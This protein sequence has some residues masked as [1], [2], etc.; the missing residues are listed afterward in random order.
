MI[1]LKIMVM[2]SIVVIIITL[3]IVTDFIVTCIVISTSH[4]VV[5]SITRLQYAPKPFSNH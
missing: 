4:C 3:M 5:I 1:M 2:T